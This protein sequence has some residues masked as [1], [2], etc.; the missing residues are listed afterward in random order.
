MATRTF[1]SST[2]T[3]YTGT[4]SVAGKDSGL[5]VL[6]IELGAV[7]PALECAAVDL[8]LGQ[9]HLSVRTDVVNGED[10]TLGQDDG[11]GDFVDHRPMRFAV[12]E[13]VEGDD[14]DV[15]MGGHDAVAL[16]KLSL[17]CGCPTAA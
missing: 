16:S 6:Q 10:L 8:A 1:P 7:Q 11:D 4:G 15:V 12:L 9:R 17:E 2:F 3:G 5:P 14:L 13:V